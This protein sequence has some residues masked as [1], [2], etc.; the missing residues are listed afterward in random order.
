MLAALEACTGARAEA[1]VGKPSEHMAAAF[2]DRLGVDPAQAA[3]VGDRLATDVAMG[4]HIGAAGILVLSGATRA[5][6]VARAD[7]R[8]DHVIAGIHELVGGGP[9]R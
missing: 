1:I 7:I 3:V 8:P 2:L 6:D 4:R 5:E 9:A